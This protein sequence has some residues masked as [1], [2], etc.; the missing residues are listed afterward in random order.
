MNSSSGKFYDL[1]Y[2]STKNCSLIYV[3]TKIVSYFGIIVKIIYIFP[4][5]CKFETCFHNKEVLFTIIG[6]HNLIHN[7]S[8]SL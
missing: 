8:D 7:I 4:R 1:I 6:A 2:D 3:K 5:T